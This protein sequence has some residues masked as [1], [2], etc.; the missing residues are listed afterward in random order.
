MKKIISSL[1]LLVVFLSGCSAKL[2]E[3]KEAFSDKGVSYEIQLISGWELDSNP[4]EKYGQSAVLG[5]SDTNSNSFMFVSTNR[6][7]EA[8]MKTFAKDRRKELAKTYG[9]DDPEDMYMKTLEWGGKEAYKYTAFTKF[10]KVEVWAHI[11]YLQTED[12]IVQIVYYSAD[13]GGYKKRSEIIEESVLS[14]E[15]T[16]VDPEWQ[17]E[18][19]E[20]TEEEIEGIGVKNDAVAFDIRGFQKAKD[21]DGNSLIVIRYKVKNLGTE[22]ILPEVFDQSIVLTQ[23]EKTLKRTELPESESE[24]EAGDLWEKRAQPIDPEKSGET[25][26]VYRLDNGTDEVTLTFTAADFPEQEPLTFDLS[27]L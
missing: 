25:V 8:D 16:E 11:Y 1:V 14:L 20:T 5:A 3:E 9:Y 17:E 7:E 13:D 22:A 21:A 2:S 24:N 19:E 6:L 4:I 10:S 26:S 12:R 15:Q 18:T 23:K 27:L